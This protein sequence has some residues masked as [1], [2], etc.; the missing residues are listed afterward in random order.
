MNEQCTCKQHED[1]VSIRDMKCSTDYI[2]QCLIN[3]RFIDYV[4]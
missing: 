4:D 3:G 1:K 2:D